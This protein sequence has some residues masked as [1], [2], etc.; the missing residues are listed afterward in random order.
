MEFLFIAKL[1][2]LFGSVLSKEL[3]SLNKKLF[4]MFRNRARS[5]MSM[6][7]GNFLFCSFRNTTTLGVGFISN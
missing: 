7:I 1:F 6:E 2:E 4:G 3:L 5:L